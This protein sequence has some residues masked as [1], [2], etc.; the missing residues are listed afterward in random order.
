MTAIVKMLERSRY[1]RRSERLGVGGL[2]DQQCAFVFEEIESGIGEAVADLR[3]C[4]YE[5]HISGVSHLASETVVTMAGLWKVEGD[6][7]GRDPVVRMAARQDRSAAIVADLFKLWEKELPRIS[8]KS[9]LAEAIRYATSRR[10]VLERF[11]IDGRVEIDSS[12][13]ER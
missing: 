8:G 4:F 13:V 10:A 7:R 1:G 9:K 2:N 6:I 5:L 12:I 3:R 11:L